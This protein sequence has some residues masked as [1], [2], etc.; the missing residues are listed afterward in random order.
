MS[1]SPFGSVCI[2]FQ[3]ISAQRSG[4][5]VS[6]RKIEIA[7][8]LIRRK[9][10]FHFINKMLVSYWKI[11]CLCSAWML[12]SLCFLICVITTCVIWYLASAIGILSTHYTSHLFFFEM[13]DK[14]G[15]W[16]IAA[17]RLRQTA[18]SRQLEQQ[19]MRCHRAAERGGLQVYSLL[20]QPWVGNGV[21]Q[22]SNLGDWPF[23]DYLQ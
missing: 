19:R 2:E 18:T 5:H 13:E 11:H 16:K 14:I 17:D 22:F 21:G 1:I 4:W 3:T 20:W 12:Y 8:A 10:L 15:T 6:L 7:V 9:L 23:P